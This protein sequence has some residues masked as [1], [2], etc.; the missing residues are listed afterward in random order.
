MTLN[1]LTPTDVITIFKDSLPMATKPVIVEGLYN[2]VGNKIYAGVWWYD[3]L[4]S[5]NDN[6]ELTIIVPQTIRVQLNHGELVQLQGTIDKAVSNSGI[7]TVQ[8]RVSDLLGKKENELSEEERE[9]IKLLEEK[10]SLPSLDVDN[11][12][13]RILYNGERKPR[14]LLLYAEASITD[15]DFNAGV[16]AASSVIDF[17]TER[18]VFSTTDFFDKLS[19]LDSAGYD[20]MCIV[21][22]GGQGLDIFDRPEVAKA[23]MNL[24]TPTIAAIGHDANMT[25]T[26]KVADRNVG[27]PSL[28]GQ[29][30]K[31]MVEQV[32]E[33]KAN[34]KA[35]LVNQVKKQFEEQIKTLEKQ[36]KDQKE[37][38][39]K[40]I[41]ELKDATDKQIAL[42]KKTV[43]DSQKQIQEKDKAINTKNEECTK[44][45][46]ENA[47]T[48]VELVKL[49]E[50]L[51][52]EKKIARMEVESK[53]YAATGKIKTQKTAIV[54][55]GILLAVV[56]VIA[57]SIATN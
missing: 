26:R 34:S 6:Y 10:A 23:V 57:I 48:K 49:N 56:V 39:D 5:L 13:K 30:F 29:Y 53:L 28:L 40:Q 55:L 42:L 24:Q 11:S 32:A 20:A 7:V 27:T 14:V 22:G 50:T 25:L 44:I 4:H 21:R 16:Q 15:Q 45:R 12:L 35:I 52:N 18:V 19:R 54:L 46:E 31:D 36:V 8:F 9:R 43:E 47:R 38:S 33:E 3:R 51:E 2:P 1:H 41:K 17:E 37:T